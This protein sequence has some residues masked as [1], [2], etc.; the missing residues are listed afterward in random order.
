MLWSCFSSPRNSAIIHLSGLL[1]SSWPF[2]VD[3]LARGFLL[4]KNVANCSNVFAISRKGFFLLFT[5]NESCLHLYWHL[6]FTYWGTKRIATKCRFKTYNLLQISFIYLISH[7]ISTDKATTRQETASQSVVQLLLSLWKW[8]TWYKNVWNS[9]PLLMDQ[10]VRG[11]HLHTDTQSASLHFQLTW[12]HFL[13][14]TRLQIHIYSHRIRTNTSLLCLL[15][16]WCQFSLIIHCIPSISYRLPV[17]LWWVPMGR[18]TF[19]NW[20]HV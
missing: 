20:K 14:Q 19:V 12:T 15:S 5:P 10:T 8:G 16:I 6:F 9:C 13:R 7:V 18:V 11:Q 3:E 1:W 4:V 17:L 2:S